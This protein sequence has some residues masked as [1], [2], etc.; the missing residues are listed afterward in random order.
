MSETS[1]HIED[2]GT[3]R[4]SSRNTE[5]HFGQSAA[6]I[7]R[8]VMSEHEELACGPRFLRPPS[9]AKLIAANFLDDSFDACAALVP[10]HGE[11][12]TATVSWLFFEA[13][14]L[15][16]NEPLESGEH[17]GQASFQKAQEF[18]GVV[19]VRH[20]RDMLTMTGSGSNGT[21]TKCGEDGDFKTQHCGRRGRARS[22]VDVGSHII[23]SLLAKSGRRRED[24]WRDGEQG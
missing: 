4:L 10:F 21:D 24:L 1:L 20:G 23:E 15:C 17:L 6:G 14:R 8:V 22:P 9:D 2:A 13:G 19:G 16:E 7:D 18:L 3:V 12:V 5:G 11:N